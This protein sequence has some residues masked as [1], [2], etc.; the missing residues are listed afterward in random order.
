M[1]LCCVL[2]HCFG[3]PGKG[4]HLLVVYIASERT[5]FNGVRS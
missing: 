1:A 2:V 5:V 4:F 3:L